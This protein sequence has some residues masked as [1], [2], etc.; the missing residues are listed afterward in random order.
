MLLFLSS[1]TSLLLTFG[2]DVAFC[3]YARFYSSLPIVKIMNKQEAAF[4]LA[5][6]IVLAAIA[7]YL[8][9]LLDG[10]LMGIVFA[11]VAKP[12][13]TRFEKRIG[14]LYA[15][16]VSTFLI[17][18]PISILM[19]YGIFQGIN[20]LIYLFIHQ[21][22][23]EE[24]LINLLRKMELSEKIVEEIRTWIPA[25]FLFMK[26][27]IKIVALDVT[28]RMVMFLMNFFISAIVCFYVLVDSESFVNKLIRIVPKDKQKEVKKFVSELDR[29]LL[30]LWFGNFAFAVIIGIV[31]IPFF[32]CFKIPYTPL[33]S[34]LMFL[35]ALMPIFA[36]W[37]V[38]APVAFFLA[39]KDL[40]LAI[41]FAATGFAFLYIIPELIIRP[42]FVGYTSRIH[43]LVL[44]LAFLGGGIAG[45][46]TG[47]FLTPM[48]VA[49]I[50]A[51]YNYYTKD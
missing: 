32:L 35:T 44:L 49:F 20:Q 12:I 45:G 17:I 28:L 25:I 3:F 31:S 38:L 51:V 43:P 19:F 2:F 41:W 7:V 29:T 22:E 40:E 26:D 18:I 21:Q 11:Y 36:E 27:K 48:L 23:V 33:L 14:K 16:L 24:M 34:G 30:N 15:S 6:V 47:F 8:S 37:M 1:L 4:I 46:I 10:I 39:L 50:T 42:Y 5:V 13:K 9:P